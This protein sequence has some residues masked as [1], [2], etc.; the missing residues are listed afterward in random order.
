MRAK[1][2]ELT[3]TRQGRINEME[4]RYQNGQGNQMNINRH[5]MA[6]QRGMA[7]GPL[8]RGQPGFPNPQL[9]QPMQ[10]SPIPMQPQPPPDVRHNALSNQTSFGQTPLR[11]YQQGQTIPRQQAQNGPPVMFTPEENARLNMM[12]QELR[13]SAS[14][15]DIEIVKQRINAS[16]TEQ[17]E[18]WRQQ[19]VDLLHMYFRNQAIQLYMRQKARFRDLSAQQQMQNSGTESALNAPQQNRLMP[20]NLSHQPNQQFGGNLNLYGDQ[21]LGLQQDAMR[22]QEAGQVVVPVSDQRISQLQQ[23]RQPI[24]QGFPMQPNAQGQ[25]MNRP[26]TAAAMANHTQLMVQKEKIKEATRMRN[27]AQAQAQAQISPG[28]QSHG[29]LPNNLQGQ[30][31]GLNNLPGQSIPR[32]SPAMPTLNRPMGDTAP[33]VNLQGTPQQ[34]VVEQARQ[35]AHNGSESTMQRSL[36]SAQQQGQYT[37]RPAIAGNGVQERQHFA[38]PPQFQQQ[39]TNMS[40]EHKKAF[41]LWQQRQM[42][43]R[44]RQRATGLSPAP[45]ENQSNVGGNNQTTRTQAPPAQNLGQ[46]G[47]PQTPITQVLLNALQST[48]NSQENLVGAT[49]V[50]QNTVSQGQNFQP[51]GQQLIG[52][53]PIPPLTEIQLQRMDHMQYPPTILDRIQL[54]NIPAGVITW[55]GLK[56]WAARNMDVHGGSLPEQLVHLQSLHFQALLARNQQERAR[57]RNMMANQES[58]VPTSVPQQ[59]PAPPAPMANLPNNAAFYPQAN[60]NSDQIASQRQLSQ[61]LTASDQEVHSMRA[62][63]PQIQGFSDDRLRQLIVQ[64]KRQTMQ[65][66]V[67]QPDSQQRSRNEELQLLRNEQLSDRVLGPQGPQISQVK[68]PHTAE[69]ARPVVSSQNN[70]TAAPLGAQAPNQ[71]RQGRNA[72]TNLD[73][74]RQSQKGVKRNNEDDPVKVSNPNELQESQ[75]RKAGPAKASQL[76]DNNEKQYPA[77]PQASSQYEMELRNQASRRIPGTSAQQLQPETKRDPSKDQERYAMEE[78]GRKTQRLVQLSKQVLENMPPTKMLSLDP[79][80]KQKI[81]KLLQDSRHMLIRNEHL[82]KVL[83]DNTED[84]NLAVDLIH[85]VGSFL[86]PFY[87]ALPLNIA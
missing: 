18:R 61:M 30:I 43:P 57:V 4:G 82:L 79:S 33:Q 13:S 77:G 64:R 78:K 60:Q 70:W 15:Q 9:Q 35:Q 7:T 62:N 69:Q 14:P 59:G 3:T 76:S 66:R 48:N 41:A 83:F 39:I 16:P 37:G 10:A 23:P 1:M 86:N 68:S 11:Q 8:G 22:S 17:R 26:D 71:S 27:Q 63:Y 32:G 50:Q 38:I 58:Q 81:G 53:R 49:A 67:P 25:M 51:S 5:Q 36:S 55:G 12:A 34:R 20:S 85:T 6:M 44:D 19:N 28:V 40:P 75:R 21:V 87:N 80:A 29:Q 45:V 73:L 31:G 84:E 2:T 72:A 46:R 54:K 65:G 56:A 47:P 52:H 24:Q 42:M 74:V